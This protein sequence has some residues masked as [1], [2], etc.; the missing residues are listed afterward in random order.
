MIGN[1]INVLANLFK[2]ALGSE[3]DLLQLIADKDIDT[4]KT[5]L[6]DHSLEI[7]KALKEYNPETHDV[8]HRRDKPRKN[9]EDYI[10]EKLPRGLQE[11]INEIAL[12]FLLGRPIVWTADPS[13]R[14][15]F[16]AFKDMLRDLRFDSH[17]RSAKRIAGSQTLTAKMYRIYR[18][19]DGTNKSEIV[20]L[21]ADK[22]WEVRPLFDVWGHL[23]ACGVGYRT[24]ESGVSVEHFDIHTSSYIHKCRKGTI[25]WQVDSVPNPTG[26]INLIVYRQDVEWKAVQRRIH[27][28]E[29]IDCRIADSNNYFAD[30]IALATA[31][32]F[33]WMK[34]SGMPGKMLLLS[35]PNK[36]SFSYLNPPSS[37]E[38]QRDEKANLRSSILQDSFT[39]DFNFE[40][41]AGMGTLSGEALRRALIL[42]YIKRER[43]IE[44]Y[45]PL[46]D[47]EKNLLLTIMEEVTH[48]G[49]ADK[50]RKLRRS[51][52]FE[53][54]EPFSEDTSKLIS[55]LASAVNAGILS[56]EEAV[57]RLAFVEDIDTELDKIQKQKA[58]P[59]DLTSSAK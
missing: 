27:R 19:S 53:F 35:D 32:V 59:K 22:G 28:D 57:K 4:A 26:K 18:D 15:A 20:M 43:N 10:T 52:R 17:M 50:I 1:T 14:E 58:D 12:F 44:I 33:Q 9:R 31:D 42:G 7:A 11:F 16:M 8:M 3:R 30:P 24:K 51:L 36:S 39:P 2:K 23:L 47:R 46:V 54:A 5:L 21:S 29:M 45:E 25:G 40:S 56:V 41:M 13:D 55:D 37:A 6:D 34:D 38:T 49:M 48:I